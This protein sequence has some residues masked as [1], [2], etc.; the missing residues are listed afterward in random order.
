M[1][2]D[3]RDEVAG[4]RAPSV[5][6]LRSQEHLE[7][8]S[9][10]ADVDEPDDASV[11]VVVATPRFERAEHRALRRNADVAGKR[12]LESARQRP[13]IHRRYDGFVD[14]VEAARQA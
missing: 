4:K 8:D 2:H 3:L 7:R 14:P 1:W 12:R 9:R 13:A 11:A 5:D 6:R 10:T